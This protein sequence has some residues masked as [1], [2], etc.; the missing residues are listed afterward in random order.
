M[1]HKFKTFIAKKKG[2]LISSEAYARTEISRLCRVACGIDTWAALARESGLGESGFLE[3]TVE[4]ASLTEKGHW[5]VPSQ[6][7]S[8]SSPGEM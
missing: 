4:G 6:R 2:C 3:G 1:W 8:A 5:F 7:H